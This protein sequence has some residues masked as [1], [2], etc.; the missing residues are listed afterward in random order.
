MNESEFQQLARLR[1]PLTAAE[2]ARVAVHLAACPEAQAEWEMEQSL[3]HLLDHLPDAPLAS[4]FTAQVLSALDR[5]AAAAARGRVVVD[6]RRWTQRWLP[7]FALT[8]L[9]VCAGTLLLYQQHQS[10]R[11]QMVR[12]LVETA[13]VPD[14][15]ALQDFDA[16]QR[17]SQVSAEPDLALLNAL[18]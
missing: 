11:E 4:N 3:N 15:E 10:E 5:E 9:V 6:W 7:R 17:L 2:Q 1:R 18:Q 12:V 14:A 13:A 16:I 8:G